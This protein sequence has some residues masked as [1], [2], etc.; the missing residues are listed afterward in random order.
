MGIHRVQGHRRSPAPASRAW[1]A[2]LAA[3]LLHL[4]VGWV[5]TRGPPAAGPTDLPMELVYVRLPP[6]PA[7]AEGSRAPGSTQRQATA[8][9]TRPVASATGRASP[10]ATVNPAEPKQVSSASDDWS[11]RVAPS[12]HEEGLRFER[13]S[14]MVSMNPIRPGPPERFR[15]RGQA[16]LAE[17]LRAAAQLL[18]W[19]PGYSDDPCAGLAEAAQALSGTASTNGRRALLEDVVRQQHQYCR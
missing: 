10:T 17:V 16:S 5:L 18:L 1:A 8:A 4:L 11:M 9:E 2:W 3:A 6:P 14:P 12:A 19:P 13:K 7:R 15:M